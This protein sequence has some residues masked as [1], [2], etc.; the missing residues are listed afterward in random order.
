MSFNEILV[1][2]ILLYKTT[3][4]LN[5]SEHLE[6]NLIKKPIRSNTK[7]RP[8]N[9]FFFYFIYQHPHNTIKRNSRH[10]K[11]KKKT[12][13]G[14]N[15][16]DNIFFKQLQQSIFFLIEDFCNKSTKMHIMSVYIM[17]TPF[18][19]FIHFAI[20]KIMKSKVLIISIRRYELCIDTG[21]M[22]EY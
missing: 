22:V 16:M 18:Q 13:A 7:N 10:N 21:Y 11:M 15:F 6:P 3:K 8:R 2:T 20:L 14:T 4:L 1:E 9:I 17:D 5:Y 12:P 19:L